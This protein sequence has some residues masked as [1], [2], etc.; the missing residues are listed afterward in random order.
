MR[1]DMLMALLHY[2]CDTKDATLVKAFEPLVPSLS[3]M[4]QTLP[5]SFFLTWKCAKKPSASADA[6]EAA[7]DVAVDHAKRRRVSPKRR[8]IRSRRS[9]VRIAAKKKGGR[10]A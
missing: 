3:A 2:V 4:A 8:S 6:P 10:G 7:G 1:W 9:S 5:K